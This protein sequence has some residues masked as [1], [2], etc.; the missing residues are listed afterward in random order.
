MW[1][2]IGAMSINLAF[3]RDKLPSWY[4]DALAMWPDQVDALANAANAERQ[5]AMAKE[6]AGR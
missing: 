5:K 4:F 3:S 6:R 1:S 2:A